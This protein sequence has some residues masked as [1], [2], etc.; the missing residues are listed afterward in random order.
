MLR[1]FLLTMLGS[2]GVGAATYF[3]FEN[4]PLV[5]E[6]FASLSR[7]QKRAMV[8]LTSLV[9]PVLAAALGVAFGYLVPT[10]DLAFLALAAGFEA[11]LTSQLVQAKDL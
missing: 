11:Y 3:V 5:D 8:M 1:T 6:W 10:E 4:V 7:K 2:T 9:L